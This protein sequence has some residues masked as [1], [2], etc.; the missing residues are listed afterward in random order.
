M[1]EDWDFLKDKIDLFHPII[2]DMKLEPVILFSQG[3][4][5]SKFENWLV[6]LQNKILKQ[7]YEV[8]TDLWIFFYKKMIHCSDMDLILVRDKISYE[9]W[10]K[11]VYY[12]WTKDRKKGWK[13][14]QTWFLK[15]EYD[16][17]KDRKQY[18]QWLSEIWNIPI[19]V[20]SLDDLI[21]TLYQNQE[22]FLENSITNQWK[23]L[24]IYFKTDINGLKSPSD[25]L[26][27]FYCF[28]KDGRYICLKDLFQVP[29]E[30]QFSYLDF[31]Y[32]AS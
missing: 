5:K 23:D 3:L 18:I 21:K 17:E 11:K 31:I 29:V 19:I 10:K 32:S 27:I 9:M 13:K 14:I 15:L 12:E 22:Y 16:S 25:Y 20:F 30:L 8:E 7:D 26:P 4:E 1:T 2:S 6:S 24:P 28:I